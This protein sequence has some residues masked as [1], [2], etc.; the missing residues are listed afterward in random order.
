[1]ALGTVTPS[2]SIEPAPRGEWQTINST[3]E[4]IAVP[5]GWIYRSRL[6]TDH[7]PIVFVRIEEPT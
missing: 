6:H 4:R 1:M 7:A 3:L 5:G 2:G